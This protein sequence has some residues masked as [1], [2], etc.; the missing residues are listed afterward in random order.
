MNASY[1]D[2][3][4]RALPV[5][6]DAVD[7]AQYAQRG[8]F[9]VKGTVPGTDAT[10]KATVT[11]V[12]NDLTVD[13]ADDTGAFHG[14][15]SG[16]LYGLYGDGVPSRNLIEGMN[17]RTVSTKAQDGPQHPGADALEVVKPLADSTDGDVPRATCS[18]AASGAATTSAG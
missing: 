1:S 6:W 5:T 7:P 9:T 4:D 17:L 12:G 8:Q 11:V 14:G 15:A 16:T 10:V 2:G 18:E 3:I 13:L